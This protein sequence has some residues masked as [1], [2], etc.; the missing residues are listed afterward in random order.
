MLCSFSLEL[1]GILIFHKNLLLEY[2][3]V[4]DFNM[5]IIFKISQKKLAHVLFVLKFE[6]FFFPKNFAF[7]KF[8]SLD[9]KYDNCFSNLQPTN[10]AFSDPNLKFFC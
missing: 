3:K 8:E 5:T 6:N 10:K 7:W 2:I 4:G 9:F 1:K